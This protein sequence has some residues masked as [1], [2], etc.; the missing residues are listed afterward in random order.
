MQTTTWPYG[1]ELTGEVIEVSDRLVLKAGTRRRVTLI[2]VKT[3]EEEAHVILSA[4]HAI[5]THAGM[6]VVIQFTKGGPTG[7]Y[8]RIVREIEELDDGN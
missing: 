6:R 3:G 8:W 1:T 2:L 7:G 5:A 4:D